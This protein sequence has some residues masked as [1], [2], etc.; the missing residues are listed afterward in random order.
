MTGLTYKP[1]ADLSPREAETLAMIADGHTAKETARKLGISH[2]T[3]EIHVANA[4]AKLGARN[5]THA[6]VLWARAQQTARALDGYDGVTTH[7]E[8]GV[9]AGSHVPSTTLRPE[10]TAFEAALPKLLE[11]HHENHFVVLKDAEVTH[12]CPT[13]EQALQWAYQHYKLDDGFFVKQVLVPPARL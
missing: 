6:A 7:P 10:I 11:E 3:V 8:F 5:Q 12:V 1:G 13:Y 2:R 9:S 4:G